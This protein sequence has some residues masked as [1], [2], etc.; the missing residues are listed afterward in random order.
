MAVL[1]IGTEHQFFQDT[2]FIE[3]YISW[4]WACNILIEVAN[5][6][7]LAWRAHC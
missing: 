6:G 1:V 5:G 2:D 7:Y 4:H 3:K